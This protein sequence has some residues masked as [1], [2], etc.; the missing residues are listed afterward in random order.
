MPGR[1]TLKA[2]I[3]AALGTRDSLTTAEIAVAVSRSVR[4]AAPPC[5]DLIVAGLIE[6][7]ERGVYRL[8][9]A[10]REWLA[11]GRPIKS[12]PKG[13]QRGQRKPWPDSFRQRAWAAMRIKPAG[14]SS[15]DILLRAARAD[16]AAPADNLGRFLRALAKGGVIVEARRA[17]SEKPGSNGLKIYRLVRDLGDVAPRISRGGAIVDLNADGAELG[18]R[19]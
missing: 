18:R 14:F 12:G 9:S 11:S 13:P 2:T 4:E 7:V 10:G 17:A 6:R 19:S 5:G 15:A 3:L 1:G 8:T 16:D